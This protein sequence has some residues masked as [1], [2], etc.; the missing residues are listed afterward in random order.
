M[1]SQNI[2]FHICF[3]LLIVMFINQSVFAQHY[4]KVKV[5]LKNGATFEGKNGSMDKESLTLTSDS[6]TQSYP[7]RD[8]QLVMAKKGSAGKWAAGFGG[9]CA[10]ICLVSIL[11][12]S[13]N[14][15]YDSGRLMLG[16]LLW[17]GIFSGAGY[18]IGALT[19]NWQ[20]VY[21]APSQSSLLSP[22]H[23]G[24]GVNRNGT[25]TVGLSHNF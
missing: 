2:L 12:Q 11:A 25:V 21:M 4:P 9:G 17:V 15:E 10:A 14:E 7:L 5:I 13:G 16:S 24:M 22:F 6:Q 1:R 3:V 19:D 23:L 20:T 18:I 8:I